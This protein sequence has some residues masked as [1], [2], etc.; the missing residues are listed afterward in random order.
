MRVGLL[1]GDPFPI[2]QIRNISTDR[3]AV[4]LISLD[5]CG[6]DGGSKTFAATSFV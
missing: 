3:R 4:Q 6:R 5:P 1:S 2:G